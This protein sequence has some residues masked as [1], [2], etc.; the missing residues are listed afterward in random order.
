LKVFLDTNVLVAAMFG[1][2]LCVQLFDRL[3]A[4]GAAVI[5]TPQVLHELR[6]VGRDKFRV[7]EPDL[8]ELLD[9]L[10]NRLVVVPDGSA[11][12]VTDCP[13]PDDAPILHGALLAGADWFV[14]G[15]KALLDL[16]ALGEMA[17]LSPRAVYERLIAL[18]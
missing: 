1:S 10:G 13:D 18:R 14:T 16:G 12:G 17:I 11:D 6:R 3:I 4:H 15:D 8:S 2:G 5:T 7:S 9:W